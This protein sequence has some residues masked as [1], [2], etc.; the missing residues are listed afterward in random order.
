MKSTPLN[1]KKD[2]APKPFDPHLLELAFK[3]KKAGLD[4]DP[5]VGCFVWDKVLSILALPSQ[6]MS[7]LS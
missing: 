1:N 4:W 7:T 5:H 3:M 2:L 6:K